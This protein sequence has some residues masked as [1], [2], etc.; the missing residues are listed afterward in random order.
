MVS[1]DLNIFVLDGQIS[2][3]KKKDAQ[4]GHTHEHRSHSNLWTLCKQFACKKNWGFELAAFTSKVQCLTPA[5]YEISAVRIVARFEWLTDTKCTD[6]HW[7][8][9]YCPLVFSLTV[10]TSSSGVSKLD[11][12]WQ[13]SVNINIFVQHTLLRSSSFGCCKKFSIAKVSFSAIRCVL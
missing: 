7:P 13:L 12:L 11:V 9:T 1:P 8:V 5:H 2:D 10:Q 4:Y 6:K 3:E